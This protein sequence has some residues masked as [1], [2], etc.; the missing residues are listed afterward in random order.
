MTKIGIPKP[1]MTKTVRA[2]S[3]SAVIV[4]LSKNLFG[5]GEMVDVVVPDLDTV[6]IRRRK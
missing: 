6:I 2:Y 1:S 3:S 4:P 5:V